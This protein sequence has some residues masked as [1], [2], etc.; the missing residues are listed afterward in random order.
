MGSLPIK[1][2]LRQVWLQREDET[3]QQGTPFLIK[4]VARVSA[5][6]LVGVLM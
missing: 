2:G 4:L 5:I 6:K 3:T 1:E